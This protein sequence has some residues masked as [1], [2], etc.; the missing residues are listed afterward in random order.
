MSTMRRQ[1]SRIC[2]YAEI[3]IIAHIAV[4]ICTTFFAQK[5]CNKRRLDVC[6][7]VYQLADLQTSVETRFNVAL[8]IGHQSYTA[9]RSVSLAVNCNTFVVA[10]S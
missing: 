6:S 5:D 10:I 4:D 9:E 2:K 1:S 8:G 3:K 7:D